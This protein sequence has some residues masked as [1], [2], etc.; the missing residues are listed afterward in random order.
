MLRPGTR[1]RLPRLSF[2]RLMC[3][4]VNN[5]YRN[6]RTRQP[7]S[8]E[9]SRQD[10][11][12]IAPKCFATSCAAITQTITP[13]TRPARATARGQVDSVG[14]VPPHPNV[15]VAAPADRAAAAGA[16]G[17]RETPHARYRCQRAFLHQTLACLVSTAWHEVIPP[18]DRSAATEEPPAI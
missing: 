16:C 17:S 6:L 9:S 7:L 4:K 12:S 14:I 5:P 10:A 3:W 18:L 13:T 1:L 15:W 11:P 8:V 2:P